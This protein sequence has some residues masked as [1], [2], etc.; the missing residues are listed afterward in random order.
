MQIIED[1][2]STLTSM[3][4]RI[5]DYFLNNSFAE[6][7]D[8]S[9]RTVAATLYVSEAALSRFAKKC[10]YK[11]YREFIF[12]YRRDKEK[13]YAKEHLSRITRRV[14]DTYDMLMEENFR[15]LDETVIRH[16]VTLLEGANRVV[17]C[18]M[19]S[20]GYAAL[21]LQMRFMCLGMD[22]TAITDS[23]MIR[24][25]TS[26]AQ[27]DTLLIALTLSGQTPE[28]LQA[29]SQASQKG[30]KSLLITSDKKVKGKELCDEIIYVTATPDQAGGTD[31]S[32]QFPILVI[33]DILYS[34]YM[35]SEKAHKMANYRTAKTAIQKK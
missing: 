24:I 22:I 28:I 34:Y 13:D 6:G 31:V 1:R 35:E 16:A 8:L 27:P 26:L 25:A 5:A 19:G 17:V 15:H 7:E 4:Q 2:Y 18:G 20:S 29:I 32:P 30:A 33:A 9:A 12:D 14:R 11:G 21:E 23:Q 10:G 3:E